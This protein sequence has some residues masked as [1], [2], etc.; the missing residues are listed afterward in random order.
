MV[1]ETIIGEKSEIEQGSRSE[2]SK[3]D[4]RDQELIFH[5]FWK[6][7]ATIILHYFAKMVRQEESSV[8]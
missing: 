1:E 2:R 4:L 5:N 8:V 3:V 6:K 7:M